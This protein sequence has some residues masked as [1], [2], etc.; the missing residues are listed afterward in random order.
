MSHPIGS[1]LLPQHTASSQRS[2]YSLNTFVPPTSSQTIA[3]RTVGHWD[4][5]SNNAVITHPNHIS[6]EKGVQHSQDIVRK[7]EDSFHLVNVQRDIKI[8]NNIYNMLFWLMDS[9]VEKPV[10]SSTW[11]QGSHVRPHSCILLMAQ[12]PRLL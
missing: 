2:L 4:L 6:L 1:P 12:T 9:I 7:A 8:L 11:D 10:F 5:F 3:N